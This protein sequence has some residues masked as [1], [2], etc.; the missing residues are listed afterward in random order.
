M[1]REEIKELRD[2]VN[3]N[4]KDLLKKAEKAY[5][6]QELKGS[7]SYNDYDT[8][9]GSRAE[10]DIIKIHEA[11]VR[12]QTL[13]DTYD[14]ILSHDEI[15]VDEKFML[16]NLKTNDEKI[17]FLRVVQGHTQK[18]IAELL[19]ISEQ[20]VRRTEKRLGIGIKG[21]TV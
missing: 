19:F 13:I 18:E 5:K 3:D 1:N 20:T 14:C 12:M 10:L 11:T 9:H 17:R 15:V 8:I 7:T 2:R 6:P 4:M 21:V 16:E